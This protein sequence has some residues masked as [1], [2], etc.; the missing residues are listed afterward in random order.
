MC[1]PV[2]EDADQARAD[3]AAGDDQRDH[4]PVDQ[5]SSFARQVV[6]ALVHEPDLD[7]AVAELFEHVVHLVRQLSGHLR[8][9]PALAP[10]AASDPP[11]REA[12]EHQVARVR[13]RDLEHVEV[14]VELD[15]DRA[16]RR[17]RLVEHHE[18]RRQPEVHRVDQREPLA[19]HLDRVDL[20]QPRAVVAVV[21][22]PQRG[23]TPP[24]APS[25]SA[26][27]DRRAA[28]AAPRRSR[29]RRR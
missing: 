13:L 5:R 3:Q 26:R 16:E 23:A 1:G 19:D 21:E 2:R 22:L 14:R 18:P 17:D 6:E 12:L 7:L 29:S 27:R 24:R 28:S 9:L 15:A 20:L 4:E 8:Q 10:R 25:G 11:R